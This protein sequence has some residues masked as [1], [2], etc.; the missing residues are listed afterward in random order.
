M[1]KGINPDIGIDEVNLIIRR[2]FEERFG[3]KQV[4]AVHT[5]RCSEN[6]HQLN[7]K[8]ELYRRRVE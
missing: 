7:L 8:R 5:V 6:A 4:I 3:R 2:L 1:I